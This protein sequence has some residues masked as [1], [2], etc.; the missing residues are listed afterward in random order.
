MTYLLKT[1]LSTKYSF[2]PAADVFEGMHELRKRKEVDLIIVDL[3]YKP[4]ESL[5]F[6]HHIKSSW[7]YQS[8]III[9]ASDKKISHKVPE[10][11]VDTFFYKPFSPIDLLQAVDDALITTSTYSM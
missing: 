9:L 7:I 1:V 10:G 6:I 3:D 11:E 4:Q 8:P 5:D 2:I